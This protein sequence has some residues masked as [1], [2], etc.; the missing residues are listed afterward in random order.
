MKRLFSFAVALCLI[1]SAVRVPFVA[2]QDMVSGNETFVAEVVNRIGVTGVDFDKSNYFDAYRIAG[3]SKS[4]LSYGHISS[5]IKIGGANV[6]SNAKE[7]SQ[8]FLFDLNDATVSS[9]PYIATFT[10]K[11]KL[12]VYGSKDGEIWLPLVLNEEPGNYARKGDNAAWNPNSDVTEL[13]ALTAWSNYN[14]ANMN[15]LLKDNAE[16]KI[17]LKFNYIGDGTDNTQAEAK[18]FG[19]T[20]SFDTNATQKVFEGVENYISSA[21]NRSAE[22]AYWDNTSYETDSTRESYFQKYMVVSESRYRGL[23][24]VAEIRKDQSGKDKLVFK[25]GHPP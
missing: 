19:I 7:T 17:Y 25:A 13:G 4:F 21:G 18:A 6:A 11:A 3:K 8:T 1:F 2:A 16:K 24:N 9:T 12:S 5:V 14:T 23:N 22:G 20:S 15:A 10:Y